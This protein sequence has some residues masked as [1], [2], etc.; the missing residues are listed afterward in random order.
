MIID[1][2]EIDL[3]AIPFKHIVIRS[4]RAYVLPTL[5]FILMDPLGYFKTK[6]ITDASVIK[7]M[8]SK[9][10]DNT[11][12][13]KEF[14]P[15]KVS[16]MPTEHHYTAYEVSCYLNVPQ[17]W[18]EKVN[19]IET[20]SSSDLIK[21][22]A[23]KFKL[24][25]DID[26]TADTQSWHI[27][28]Q[29]YGE[30]LGDYVIPHAYANAQSYYNLVVTSDGVLTYK[31]V[32]EVIK[33][34]PK[35]VLTNLGGNN[36]EHAFLI[37]EYIPRSE[38]GYS[39]RLGGYGTANIGFHLVDGKY[40]YDKG[41][42]VNT[43]NTLDMDKK[44]LGKMTKYIFAP[45]N[46]GNTGVNHDRARMQNDRLGSVFS[47]YID[48]LVRN[49]TGIAE[50]TPIGIKVKEAGASNTVNEAISGNYVAIGKAQVA[51]PNQYLEKLC[52]VRNGSSI[53][54]SGLV[55]G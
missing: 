41:V 45:I 12:V 2:M 55:G 54:S 48:V 14:T 9:D 52:F 34:T 36:S 18:N 44:M 22:V 20:S 31:N 4:H 42:D 28:N 50:L 35:I 46:I 30:Y 19:L 27:I 37:D 1:D 6:P 8:I 51:T 40:I 7:V 11:D 53:K 49:Y 29:T 13:F 3:R 33:G 16:A 5:E 21:S 10:S 24:K 17:Y 38:A 26:A 32:S 15:F 23:N 47:N 39:N 43:A 25:S